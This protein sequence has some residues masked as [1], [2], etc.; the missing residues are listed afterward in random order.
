MLLSSS[1]SA[2]FFAIFRLFLAS[3]FCCE[4]LLMDYIRILMR[5]SICYNATGITFHVNIELSK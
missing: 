4:S 3:L 1:T 5:T 2:V